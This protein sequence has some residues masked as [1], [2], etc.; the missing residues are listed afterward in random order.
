MGLGNG[1]PNIGNKGSNFK[2]E[3]AVLLNLQNIAASSGGGATEATLLAVLA[4]LQSEQEFEQNLVM[5]LG[6]AG[7]PGNC[8]TYLQVRIFN[9]T[10]HTFD[11]PIYYNAA[12]AV[13]VPV[14]PLQIVN[15]Q[16]VLQD[17][18]VQLQAINADLDV[19]LSTRASEATLATMLTLAGFQARI[20]TLGQKTMANSTPV[21]LASDQSSIP[22]TLAAA[23]AISAFRTNA[24]SNSAIAVKASAGE[25]WGWNFV[26]PNANAVY[27]KFYNTAAGSVVV[28]TTAIVQ[29]L[30]VPGNGSVY[31]D[32]NVA[33]HIYATAISMACVTGTLDTDATAPGTSIIAE[34]KYK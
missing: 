31:Q 20:N 14:G 22:V 10:T 5:D 4:A 28:G 30:M 17:I 11:P 2:Y 34:I 25:T 19:A 16:Y 15:P 3:L 33:Q 29:T 21:V 6:G 1:N 8:P 24:L 26:N 7:C 18:L 23:T 32:P 27:V 13:V 12:G 9:Q